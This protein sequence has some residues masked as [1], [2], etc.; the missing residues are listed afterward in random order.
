MFIIWGG[1]PD[2]G[3]DAFAALSR[4]GLTPK[5]RLTWFA[6]DQRSGELTPLGPRSRLSEMLLPD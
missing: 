1:C 4:L 3:V 5:I 2:I 6:T